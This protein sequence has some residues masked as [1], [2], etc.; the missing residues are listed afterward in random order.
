[1]PLKMVPN[2]EMET[3]FYGRKCESD[4]VVLSNDKMEKKN[5]CMHTHVHPHARYLR[6]W[7]KPYVYNLL[8]LNKVNEGYPMETHK[9]ILQLQFS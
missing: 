1:M 3:N 7:H 9:F 6:W 2:I 8:D 5:I 4:K